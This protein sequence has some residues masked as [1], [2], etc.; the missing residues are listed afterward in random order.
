MLSLGTKVGMKSISS[1]AMNQLP[2]I[3]RKYTTQL[4]YII[5]SSAFFFLF[6][7]VYQPFGTPEAFD[8]GRGLFIVNV[9][10]LTSILLVT[11]LIFRTLF[12]F[13]S[14]HLCRNWWQYIGW[15]MVEFMAL[16]YFFALYLYLMSGR[17]VP[18]FEELAYCLQYSFL[19]LMYPYFGITIVCVVAA[20]QPQN[21]TRE[22]ESIRFLDASR[23]VKLVLLKDAILCVQADQ[24]YIKVHYL[25]NGKLKVYSLRST[26]RAI[27]PLMEQSG[28]FRC[29]RSY[30]V[31][32]A[33][34]VAVRKDPNDMISAEL[35]VPSLTIPVSRKVYHALSERL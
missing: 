29:H 32:T 20:G 9:A 12:Y 21:A 34:I 15:I 30:Y 25:D 28:L 10:I 18:Y 8:M 22:R 1:H 35:D 7:A 24:N 4:W 19:V 31:N 6:M 13:L 26:M 16:T 23:Q 5:F 17:A 33:H 27:E 11:L 14:R 3:F 2:A